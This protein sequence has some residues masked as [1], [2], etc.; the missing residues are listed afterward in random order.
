VITGHTLLEQ[1]RLGPARLQFWRDTEI[2]DAEADAEGLARAALGLGGIT[3]C[4]Y[5][6]ADLGAD[7]L[8]GEKIRAQI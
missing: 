4:V 1:G 5:R 6:G 3:R 2:A 8:K 7:P